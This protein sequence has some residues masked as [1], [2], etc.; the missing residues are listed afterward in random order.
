MLKVSL[1]NNRYDWSDATAAKDTQWLNPTFIYLKDYY[2]YYS[3]FKDQ[4]KWITPI[5]Q[6][7]TVEEYA[8][9][10]ID[11]KLDVIG[12]GFYIWNAHIWVK[13]ANLVR[14]KNPKILIFGGG[15][16]IDF[17]DKDYAANLA[18]SFDYVVKYDGEEPFRIVLD[19]LVQG[20][21]LTDI[22]QLYTI[23][24]SK[25]VGKFTKTV[26]RRND[27]FQENSPILN[28]RDILLK[29]FS[30]ANDR[31]QKIMMTWGTTR[32]CPYSCAFCDWGVSEYKKVGKR[33]PKLSKRELTFLAVNNVVGIVLE[34]ANWGMFKADID[35]TIHWSRL[36][37][38]Y[39]MLYRENLSHSKNNKDNVIKIIR[40]MAKSGMIPRY[41]AALQD[42]DEDVLKYNDRPDISW[43]GHQEVIK[44]ISKVT[45]DTTMCYAMIITGMPGQTFN[46]IVETFSKLG[47]SNLFDNYNIM[48]FLMLPGAPMNMPA[49]REKY[50]VQHTMGHILE[51]HVLKNRLWEKD[52]NFA[53][54]PVKFLTSSFSFTSHEYLNIIFMSEFM[55][56]FN[57]YFHSVFDQGLDRRYFYKN[58]PSISNDIMGCFFTKATNYLK[59]HFDE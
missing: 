41:G 32:G 36:Y 24:D 46:S 10:I 28:N 34:D 50:Q 49:H 23:V 37:T 13:V 6:D 57:I 43:E 16:D 18:P 47:E 54:F 30:E 12:F 29:A 42:L 17:L 33:N 39:K 45:Q 11:S 55:R 40:I 51:D 21:P 25:M 2:E 52:T 38:R 58:F 5:W 48:P 44:E 20:K 8:N 35:I 4:V 14:K 59:Y 3:E 7:S 22:D 31:G 19:N 1:L 15:P 56:V 9:W 26:N 53:T 27:W